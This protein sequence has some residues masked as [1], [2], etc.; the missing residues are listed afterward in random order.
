MSGDRKTHRTC[1]LLFV[2]APE[3]ATGVPKLRDV[4]QSSGA[5]LTV[6]AAEVFVPSVVFYFFFF[7]TDV[8]ECCRHHHSSS[9]GLCVDGGEGYTSS[10]T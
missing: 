9:I 8:N 3:A 1:Q 5:K 7:L 10:L 2:F 4:F 6:T